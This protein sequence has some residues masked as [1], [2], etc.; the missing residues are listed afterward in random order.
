MKP[1]GHTAAMTLLLH[2]LFAGGQL[3][4]PCACAAAVHQ[5]CLARWVFQSYQSGRA[6]A[7]QCEVCQ[8]EWTGLLTGAP[9]TPEPPCLLPS[10][11]VGPC[12]PVCG[13]LWLLAA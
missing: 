9:T 1:L 7:Q 5:R 12:F 11:P 8:Q 2:G 4:Q 13:A 6:N 3:I 10:S